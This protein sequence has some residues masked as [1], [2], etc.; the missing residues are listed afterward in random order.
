ML[1]ELTREDESDR[2]LNLSGSNG[3]S[4][5]IRSELGSLGCD[6]LENVR[7]KRVENGH[8][9]V[10]TQRVRTRRIEMQRIGLRDT[11]VWVDL[12]EDLV[13]VRRVRLDPLLGSFLATFGLG[14]G[15]CGLTSR[16][17]GASEHVRETTYLGW[18]LG[19]ADGGL[20]CLRSGSFGSDG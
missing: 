6:P 12:F 15:L 5:V 14:G 2:G 10:A 8:G 4:V 11:S 16:V 19:C 1:G 3:R 7:H 18:G 9:L 13:D 17:R 20:G